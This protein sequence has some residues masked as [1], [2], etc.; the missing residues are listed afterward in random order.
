MK[1]FNT[2]NVVNDLITEYDLTPR[3]NIRTVFTKM[4]EYFYDYFRYTE[5]E[6][7]IIAMESAN[8]VASDTEMLNKIYNEIK[9]RQ[10]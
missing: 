1:E 2:Y 10:I 8:T 4:Y 6:N 3:D 5:D 7:M 9:E